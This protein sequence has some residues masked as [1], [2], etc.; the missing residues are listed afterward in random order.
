MGELC[1]FV[2]VFSTGFEQVGFFRTVYMPI[3]CFIRSHSKAFKFHATDHKAV[4]NY[5]KEL[6]KTFSES[7]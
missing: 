2:Q 4:E 7:K 6:C 5:K 1:V 3:A